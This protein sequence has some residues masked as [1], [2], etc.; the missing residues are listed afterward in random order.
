MVD[1]KFYIKEKLDQYLEFDSDELFKYGDPLIFGGA[2]RDIIANQKI[3][4]IDI[5]VAPKTYLSLSNILE[6]NGYTF[7]EKLIG[8][9]ISSMYHPSIAIISEPITYIKGNKV[10]QLIRPNAR[11]SERTSNLAWTYNHPNINYKD[12]LDRLVNEVDLSCC[13]ISYNGEEVKEHFPNAILHAKNKVYIR[14]EEG[15]MSTERIQHRMHKL[16]NRGWREIQESDNRD[17]IIDDVL[18][19]DSW[20]DNLN[21]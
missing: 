9:D 7:M 17:Y 11:A 16:G 19:V 3:H 6:V 1:D 15:V 8:R 2:I 20:F 18:D 10:V 13:G 14:N 5:L 12:T 4:D 21:K